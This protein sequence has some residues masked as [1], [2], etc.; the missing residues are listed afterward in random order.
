LGSTAAAAD[1][2]TSIEAA[3]AT[4]PARTPTTGTRVG[5]DTRIRPA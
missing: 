3:R 4:V 2:G 5:E 1:D